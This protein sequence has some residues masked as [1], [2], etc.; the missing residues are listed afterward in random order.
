MKDMNIFEREEKNGIPR[1]NSF[2]VRKRAFSMLKIEK[3]A[4]FPL[5]KRLLRE[6]R[7]V[8][9]RSSEE[10]RRIQCASSA[11]SAIGGTV[12]HKSRACVRWLLER[13]VAAA[14]QRE[15][16]QKEREPSSIGTYC[17]KELSLVHSEMIESLSRCPLITRKCGNSR[18]T[19]NMH[20]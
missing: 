7:G 17:A 13:Q 11:L 15:K 19:C 1:N 16:E 4:R 9:V 10:T 8:A 5:P 14:E 18:R 20:H 6:E 12:I 3:L 2:S